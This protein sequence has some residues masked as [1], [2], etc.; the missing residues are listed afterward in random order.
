MI[1]R[2]GTNAV[3]TRQPARRVRTV[4]SA[5]LLLAVLALGA[6]GCGSSGSGLPPEFSD[7]VTTMQETGGYT[8]TATVTTG[9]QEATA[10]SVTIAGTFQ[11]PNRVA[12]TVTRSNSAPVVMVLDGGTVHVQDPTTKAWSTQPSTASGTV[13]LRRTFGALSSAKGVR[14]DGATATFTLG[15]EA[16]KTLAGAGVTG[17]ATVTITLGKVG[18]SRLVYRATVGG[19]PVEVT[20]DYAD[21]GTAPRVTVPV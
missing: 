2:A 15:G 21:I 14:T 4:L 5:P 7:A 8:F 12:Q 17:D 10:S 19:S 11:A 18:L 16:A 1:A 6:V 9:D 20:L 13:D 3:R